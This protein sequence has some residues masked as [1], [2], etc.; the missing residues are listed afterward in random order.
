[1]SDL[2]E[3]IKEGFR[4]AEN[5]TAPGVNVAK[6]TYEAAKENVLTTRSENF[7]IFLENFGSV[8]SFGG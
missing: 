4:L 8:F 7:Q 3:F 1:M 6:T 5:V 2:I